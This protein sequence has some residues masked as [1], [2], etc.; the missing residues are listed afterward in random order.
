MNHKRKRPKN[1]RAGCLMCKYW[2][3]NGYST[4]KKDGEQF[5]S[6][7]RRENARRDIKEFRD[8]RVR[9]D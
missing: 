3:V 8:G 7:R 6:H 2:K 5:G 4:E 9:E 1:Q